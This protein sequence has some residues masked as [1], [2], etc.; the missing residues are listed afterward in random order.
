MKQK[1]EPKLVISHGINHLQRF[2]PRFRRNS[3]GLLWPIADWGLRPRV[4]RRPSLGGLTT[5]ATMSFRMNGMALNTARY[6]G[7]GGSQRRRCRGC[8]LGSPGFPPL[9]WIVALGPASTPQ[10]LGGPVDDSSRSSFAAAA[11]VHQTAARW[12]ECTLAAGQLLGSGAP[13]KVRRSAGAFS[14]PATRK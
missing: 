1:N 9:L 6:R 13:A 10:T 3:Y 11:S 5:K 14:A 12:P 2:W 4:G 7:L 8:R